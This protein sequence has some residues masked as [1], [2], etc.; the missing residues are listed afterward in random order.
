MVSKVPAPLFIVMVKVP[1]AGGK[2]NSI[3]P[4]NSKVLVT[5]LQKPCCAVKLSI[6]QLQL[7]AG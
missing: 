3:V 7:G 4:S 5:P 1:V 2:L 6:L